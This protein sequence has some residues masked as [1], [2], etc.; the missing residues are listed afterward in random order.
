MV[1][2]KLFANFREI[3]GTKEVEIKAKHLSE[4][5]EELTKRFPELKEV[6]F[7]GEKLRDY[8]NIMVNGKF[9]RKNLQLELRDGDE[10]AIFPPVSGG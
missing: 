2:V 6:M 10:V 1:K 7:E 9:E 8:V 4:L 3:A 5:L